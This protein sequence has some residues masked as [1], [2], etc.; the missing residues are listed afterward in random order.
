M[1]FFGASKGNLNGAFLATPW[2]CVLTALA[3]LSPSA[4]DVSCAN[5]QREPD[6]RR[7]SRNHAG[8]KPEPMVRWIW[9][10][11]KARTTGPKLT[12]HCRRYMLSRRTRDSYPSVGHYIRSA[13]PNR[14]VH[15]TNPS[16]TNKR[17]HCDYGGDAGEPKMGLP[18]SPRR[19][20]PDHTGQRSRQKPLEHFF[21]FRRAFSRESKPPRIYKF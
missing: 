7:I 15:L 17:Q 16:G 4:S 3:D 19:D 11:P 20:G 12:T 2:V 18:S 14:C 5:E 13:C 21:L 8:L 6:H 1:T 9:W 10:W